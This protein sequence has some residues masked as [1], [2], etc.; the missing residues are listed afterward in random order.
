[1]VIL[2]KYI[3]LYTI[4]PLDPDYKSNG[5]SCIYVAYKKHAKTISLYLL[6]TTRPLDFFIIK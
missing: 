2:N 4:Q 6:M 1:M 3:G 5:N